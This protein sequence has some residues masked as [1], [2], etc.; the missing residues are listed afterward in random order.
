MTKISMSIRDLQNI[1]ALHSPTE[2]RYCVT[3]AII[4]VPYNKR[5]S[6]QV[7]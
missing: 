5:G 6:E 4:E 3:V 2:L 7:N 1:V